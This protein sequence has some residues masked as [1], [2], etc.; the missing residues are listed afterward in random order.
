MS[1][2]SAAAGPVLRV[3]GVGKC[4][5][6]GRGGVGQLWDAL[7]RSPIHPGSDHDADGF[8]AVRGIDLEIQP[9][10]AVGLIGRNGAGKSTLLQL[11]TGTLEPTTGRVESSGRVAALLELGTGFDGEYTGRENVF[12]NG[13]LYGLSSREIRQRLPDILA[14]AD[15]GE[16]IDRPVKWYSSG[17][18][19]RLAFAIVAHLDA[20]VL[21]IDEALAVGDAAFNRKCQRFLREFRQ[22]GTMILVSHDMTAI[23][24]LCSRVVWLDGGT[25]HRI[26]DPEPVCREF[27]AVMHGIPATP[28]AQ[29]GPPP[30]A[31]IGEQADAASRAREL[32]I[33]LSPRRNDIQVGEFHRSSEQFGSGGAEI[34]D[35]ELSDPGG[36]ALAWAV[37][38]QDV[39]LRVTVLAR[40]DLESP[41]IGFYLK[42]ERG[43]ELLGENTAGRY[44]DRPVPCE[45]GRVLVAEFVFRMPRLPRGN[46][47]INAAVAEGS[48][49]R[50]VQLHWMHDALPL[51][52]AASTVEY[53]LA[54]LPLLGY[55]RASAEP[56]VRRDGGE[57]G[58]VR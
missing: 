48:Q 35:V 51:T 26:G 52:V 14:F 32:A 34:V 9:G 33:D 54:Q 1:R 19:V 2:E 47:S 45:A 56:P 38:G 20:E 5:R 31:A 13:R 29:A 3:D 16:F 12:L 55:S 53:G 43:Q 22:H 37:G 30:V 44:Q 8:W 58:N 27:L 36:E 40:E 39:L 57:A 10:E 15:I 46:Y 18:F 50:H 25:L 49:Y 23:Q 6:S 42:N 11:L 28:S 4:Y 24:R 17:M 21:I 7:R 41:I